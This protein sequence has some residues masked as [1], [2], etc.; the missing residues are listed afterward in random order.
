MNDVRYVLLESVRAFASGLLERSKLRTATAR[1]HA[2]W[3]AGIGDE[4]SS[5]ISFEVFA[6]LAPELDN[7][8]A[9][10]AWT[11]SYTAT[12]IMR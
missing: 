8:R 9:A 3:L 12:T 10:L 1:S 7:A 5:P 6:E 11:L 2:E 4:V